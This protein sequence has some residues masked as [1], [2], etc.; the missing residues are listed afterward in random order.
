MDA[1]VDLEAAGILK[2]KIIGST[3]V[4]FPGVGHL[5]LA[6]SPKDLYRVVIDFLKTN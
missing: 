3:Q 5:L 4:T 1:V 6:E 2:E